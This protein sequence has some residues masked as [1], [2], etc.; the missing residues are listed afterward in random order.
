MPQT[1]RAKKAGNS[2][3]DRLQTSIDAAETALKDL[4]REVGRESQERLKD[5]G[6][7]LTATRKNL[8]RSRNRI[9]KDLEQFEHRLMKGKAKGKAKAK[10]RVRSAP[11]KRARKTSRA[12]TTRSTRTTAGKSSAKARSTSAAKARSKRP[13]KPAAKKPAAR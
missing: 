2:A 11:K 6:T 1:R 8:T 12:S 9:M 4:R 5:V 3:L 13:A 10:A 7:T